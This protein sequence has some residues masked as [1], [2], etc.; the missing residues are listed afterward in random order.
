MF[1]IL[2]TIIF[3]IIVNFGTGF[4][5]SKFLKTRELCFFQVS[6]YGMMGIIFIET[7][8]AFFV[9][10][11]YRVEITLFILGLSGVLWFV[12]GKDITILEFRKN[13]DFSFWIFVILIIFLGSFSPYLYDHYIYYIST[14]HYLKEIGFVKG[15][16]NLD[17]LLGQTSFWHIYQ[18]GFS[19]FI[20]VN[21]RINTYLLVLFLIYIYQNKKPAFLVFFPFFLIFIQQPS[22]DLP[23][24]ILT[25]IILNEIIERRNNTFV[26]AL[27][28]FAFCIKPISFWLP[29]LVILES[30]H[31]GSFKLK[32]LIPIFIFS[33][34]FTIKNIWLFGFP[35]FPLSLLDLN[36]AWKPSK[37]ILTYSSQIGFMK[38]YD[39]A[40]SY[41]QISEFNIWEKIYHWFTSG[42]KSVF[43]IAIVLC[44]IVLGVF[45]V[46]KKGLLYKIIFGSIIVKSVLLIII[47]AQYRF[48][49][50]VYLVT[51]FVLVKDIS[52][53]KTIFTAVFLSVLTAV[54]FTFPDFVKQS[55]H[56]GKRMSGFTASQLIR[57]VELHIENY[58]SYQFGN[59][60]FN[61][62]EK[63]IEQAPFPAIPLYWLKT[64][65]YYNIFPQLDKGGFVQRKMTNEER[66]ELKKIIV[67]LEKSTP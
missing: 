5:I 25:L 26:L 52:Y 66:L 11:D 45:A 50:D 46:K 22:P 53:E 13:L 65:E 21:F 37:E 31:S 43:N 48:F 35:V 64:Y 1:I 20:D 61:A 7:L 44:L 6:L 42:Y 3:L 67:D 12:K 55:F 8:C 39:M 10:L 36:F 2:K 14:I 16:S 56:L 19:D 4:I 28:L 40:Y 30:F 29:I 24:F 27:S 9:P 63:L 57:P 58:K 41:Q 32:S 59:L 23:V 47:S 15:I 49:I 18:S 62:T 33:L 60:K 17:L 51:I 34:M 54:V 38:S